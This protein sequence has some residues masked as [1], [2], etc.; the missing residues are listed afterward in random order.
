MTEIVKK[1]APIILAE[2][3]KANNILLHCHPSADPDSVGSALAMKFALESLNKKVTLIQGDNDIPT[4]F[5]FPGVSSIV[6][7]SYGE[8]NTADFDL[9]IVLDSGAKKMISGKSEVIFPDSMKV[10]V[11]DHHKSNENYGH[12]NCVDSTYPST[13]QLLFDLFDEMKITI[14]HDIAVNL[15]MGMYT[16][17]GGFRYNSVTSDTLRIASDLAKIAPDFHKT[18]FTMENSNRKQT[19][20]F[21]GLA[22]SSVKGYFDGKLMI[23]SVDNKKLVQNEIKEDDMMVSSISTKLKSVIGNEICVTIV[24]KEPG[25]C[26]ISF[27]TR[28]S[29]K[30]DL[31]KIAVALGGGG[32]VAAA[33]ATLHMTIPNAIDKVVENVALIYNL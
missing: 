33:G 15:F 13:A 4:A 19:L 27:R 14:T 1:F 17:T 25:F 31:T 20:I 24:E 7:K 9:F 11:V 29:Q 26:K 22:L 28:D 10:I 8:I 32:H 18:I 23:A 5:D 21:E 30:Y 2:I 12:I 6:K 3:N 16:D